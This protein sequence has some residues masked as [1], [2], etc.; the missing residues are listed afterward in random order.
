MA[1][2]TKP[3]VSHLRVLFF[4]CVVRTATAH[5]DTKTLNMCHQA[6]K[7]FRGIFVRI[8]EHQKGYLVYVPSTMNIIYS[9]NVVFD[10]SIRLPESHGLGVDSIT[11]YR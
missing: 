5:V 10:L 11:E 7:G 6:Q 3:S 2:S 4:P 8:P 1:T 9:Y